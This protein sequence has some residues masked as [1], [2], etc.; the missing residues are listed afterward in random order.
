[1]QELIYYPG[2]EVRNVSWLKFALLYIETLRPI[3]PVSGDKHI[4]NFYSRI[5]NETDLIERFRPEENY[6]FDLSKVLDLY[7]WS[8]GMH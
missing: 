8:V 1:M 6:Y 3:I 4:S 5:I 7:S 2:F